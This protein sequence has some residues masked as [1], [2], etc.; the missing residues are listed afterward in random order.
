MKNHRM[1]GRT[2]RRK[3]KFI[4]FSLAMCAAVSACRSPQQRA[5]TPGEVKRYHLEGEVLS[6]DAANKTLVVNHGSIPG[7]MPAC[8]IPVPS[9]C[10]SKKIVLNISRV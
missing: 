6:V 5:E 1:Y 9:S 7:F 2:Q 3:G 10:G 8:T 4:V